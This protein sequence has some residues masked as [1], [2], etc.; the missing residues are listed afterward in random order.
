MNSNTS[1][2]DTVDLRAAP[3]PPD[4]LWP[5][6]SSSKVEV[7]LAA[8]SDRGLVRENNQDHYLV[9]RIRRS[10]ETLLTNLQAAQVPAQAEEI[11][12]GLVV[13]DGM[14]GPAGGEVASQ[15]AITTLV[16]LALHTPDWVVGI[17]PK[18]TRRRMQR[19]EERWRRVQEALRQRGNREPALGQMGT[20]MTAAVSLGTRLVVGHVGDSRVYIFRQGQLHQLTLDHTLVQMMVDQG[21]LTPEQAA[22]HPQRHVLLRSFNAGGDTVQGDFQQALLTDGDQLLL[23]TDGLTDMVATEVISSVLSRAAS[24]DEAC[25]VLLAAALKNGGKDNV[26]IA[27]ARYRFPQ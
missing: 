2:D 19:M 23:C 25:Q 12:Y 16:S 24:A 17:R 18:D 20:T 21:E 10:L 6:T 9:V 15:L 4:A 22:I 3:V 13:A 11:A 1:D 7:D 14:G 26:T 5:E 8:V 27:L